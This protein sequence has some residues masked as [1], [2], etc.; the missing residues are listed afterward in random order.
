MSNIFRHFERCQKLD[1]NVPLRW[2]L[3][4]KNDFKKYYRIHW[5]WSLFNIF[6]V[7]LKRKFLTTNQTELGKYFIK[8][9]SGQNYISSWCIHFAMNEILW[10]YLCRTTM[11]NIPLE[12]NAC[13]KITFADMRS[14]YFYIYIFLNTTFWNL[15]FWLIWIGSSSFVK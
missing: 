14:I 9:T 6:G 1:K 13:N 3:Q 10:I 12:I 8:M 11:L 4:H 5:I 15:P 2:M 7:M